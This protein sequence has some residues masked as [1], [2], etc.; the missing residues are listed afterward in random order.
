MKIKELIALNETSLFRKYLENQDFFGITDEEIEAAYGMCKTAT[1]ELFTT[2]LKNGKLYQIH[3]DL[4]SNKDYELEYANK[5][6][7]IIHDHVESFLEKMLEYTIEFYDGSYEVRYDYKDSEEWKQGLKTYN[8]LLDFDSKIKL[9]DFR[10]EY[11]LYIKRFNFKRGTVEKEFKM[12]NS[13]IEGN[14]YIEECVKS[15]IKSNGTSNMKDL[16]SIYDFEVTDEIDKFLLELRHHNDID[17][18]NGELCLSIM[19][20]LNVTPKLYFVSLNKKVF[21]D[22]DDELELYHFDSREKAH[23]K[24]NELV[25]PYKEDYPEDT[26]GQFDNLCEI[27]CEDEAHYEL[28]IDCNFDF[29]CSLGLVIK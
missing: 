26:L 7:L 14:K 10:Y 8:L 4:V 12:F 27:T 5:D 24:F 9:K 1:Y 25:A 15:F 6:N 18:S 22:C 28:F 21:Y 16:N 2:D 11:K 23:E 29:K 3:E 13:V 17:I 20:D 19:S